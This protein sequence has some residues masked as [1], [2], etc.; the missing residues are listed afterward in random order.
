M[1]KLKNLKGIDSLLKSDLGKVKG[2]TAA[3]PCGNCKS[4]CMQC[5]GG[6]AGVK[7]P[8]NFELED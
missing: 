5:V 7:Q 6:G 1:T 2:G 4:N 3:S 8:T